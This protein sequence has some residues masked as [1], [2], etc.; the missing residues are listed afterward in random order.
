LGGLHFTGSS[1]VFIQLNQ[2]IA[3]RLKQYRSFPRIVGETGGK[4]MHFVH[5]SANVDSVIHQ[6][7]RAAFDYQGQKCSAASRLYV[8]ASL[9]PTISEGL[10]KNI[11]LIKVGPVDDFK[12]FMSAVIHKNAFDKCVSYIEYAKK[13]NHKILAGGTC[14]S[15]AISFLKLI[16]LTR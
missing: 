5:P 14:T 12:N 6:T 8:P 10:I 7:I 3:E 13:F 9:W 4:N 15:L 16:L 11:S 2:D 1:E